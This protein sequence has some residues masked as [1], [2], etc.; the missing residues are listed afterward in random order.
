MNSVPALPS[1]NTE[2]SGKR[3]LVTGGTKGAG[4][5]IVRRLAAGGATVATTARSEA[6]SDSAAQV[7]V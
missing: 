6:P 3:I 4:E 2:F 5:A 1:A 7:F